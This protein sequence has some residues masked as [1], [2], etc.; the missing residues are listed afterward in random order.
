MRSESSI[1]C[2]YRKMPTLCWECL[3]FAEL[4]QFHP[5]PPTSIQFSGLFAQAG[6]GAVDHDSQ[7]EYAICAT[8]LPILRLF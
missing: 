7:K 2:E 3:L 1:F 4:G 8:F 5:P 6:D